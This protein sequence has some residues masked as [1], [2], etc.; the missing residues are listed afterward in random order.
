M[1]IIKITKKYD[2]DTGKVIK[3]EWELI[4][5]YR[6]YN[7]SVNAL[8]D[9]VYNVQDIDDG[10]RS[11]DNPDDTWWI[12]NYWD[13]NI[14]VTFRLLMHKYDFGRWWFE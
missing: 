14:E 8:K 11:L 9:M 13:S 12:L 4:P 3:D 6:T 10:P 7:K 2:N 1:W 5:T